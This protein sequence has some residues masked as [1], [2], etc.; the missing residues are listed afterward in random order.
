MRRS[1]RELLE[2]VAASADAARD[3]AINASTWFASDAEAADRLLDDQIRE[4][5]TVTTMSGETFDGLV[6]DVDDRSI[7]MQDAGVLKPDG[8]RIPIDGRLILGRDR[9]DYM[10]RVR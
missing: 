6:E 8:A 4:R 1:T 10:Q 9:I 2:R 7:V 3:G 5:L